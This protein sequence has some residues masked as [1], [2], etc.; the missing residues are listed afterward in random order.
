MQN[1]FDLVFRSFG[2]YTN[3]STEF[4]NKKYNIF[5]SYVVLIADLK[6]KVNVL[7]FWH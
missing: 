2:D 5:T 4:L 3:V 1:K 6:T 7:C